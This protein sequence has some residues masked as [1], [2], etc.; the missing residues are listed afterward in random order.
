MFS[1]AR[2]SLTVLL[3]ALVLGLWSNA[4]NAAAWAFDVP[5]L[6]AMA[7]FGDTPKDAVD[8]YV[9]G[10]IRR[11]AFPG[12]EEELRAWGKALAARPARSLE[13]VAHGRPLSG[14]QLNH[15]LDLTGDAHHLGVRKGYADG[16]ERAG[17]ATVFFPP[18]DSRALI[19]ARLSSVQHLMLTGG[20]DLHP[21]LY[22]A[23]VTYAHPDELNLVR[24][25][26]ELQLVRKALSSKLP[27]DATCRGYQ[28][29]DVAAGGT[30]VQ[31]LH[32]DHLTTME[33]A[34]PGF[35]P[36]RHG[37]SVEPGSALAA[38]IGI[39]VRAVP[40]MHHEAIGKVGKGFRVV[41]RAPDGVPEAIEADGG[42]VR[43]YQF[44]AEKTLRSGFSKAIYA[45][46]FQRAAAYRRATR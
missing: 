6:G 33:H 27:I 25:R 1:A 40:S 41:G 12:H 3:V 44:H 23:P 42:R 30:L 13:A 45:N 38:T 22:G 16:L 26:F 17:V 11:Q 28:M 4:A 5:G 19:D 29:L 8:H 2:R 34:G 24:D 20:D 18:A 31:D 14:I 10:V 21:K 37:V 36:V 15:L 7:L 9:A 32:E 39:H 35:A 43:G 46:M